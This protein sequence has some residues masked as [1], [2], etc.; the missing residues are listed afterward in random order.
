MKLF[1]RI[2]FNAQVEFGGLKINLE[3]L[4]ILADCRDLTEVLTFDF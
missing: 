4:M 3:F 2:I 1:L